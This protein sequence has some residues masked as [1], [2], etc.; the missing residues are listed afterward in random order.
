MRSLPSRHVLAAVVSL[1]VAPAV[2]AEPAAG[3]SAAATA[4]APARPEPA[5][6][7]AQDA[8]AQ[9][10]LEAEI[11]KELGQGA[12]AGGAHAALGAA[13]APAPAPQG[14]PEGAKGGNPFARVLL[15]PDISAIGTFAGAYDGYDVNRLSPRDGPY[16]PAGKPT[17]LFRELELGLQSVIDPYLRGDVFIS[18][19]PS[20]VA[21]EE[22]Y[23]TTLGLPAGLQLRAGKLFSPFGRLNQQHPHVWDF[24]DAPLALNRLLADEVLS[25]PG[26]D[27]SWLAPLPWFAELSV[28]GQGTSPT[29][30][31]ED[32]GERLTGVARLLQYFNLGDVTTVGVGL[33]AAR[34]SEATGAFRDLGGADVYV[35]FRRAASRASVSLQGEIVTVKVTDPGTPA[36]LKE[37]MPLLVSAVARGRQTG[38]Y[39]QLFWRPGPHLGYGVRYDQAPS[40]GEAAPGDERRYSAVATW[41]ASEFQRLR[42]QA[43]YDTR[44]ASQDGVEVLVGL[45]FIMGSHGAHPF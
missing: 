26:V 37:A 39:A 13:P 32:P 16:G 4:A 35:K 25:G 27:A 19:T 14:Q 6:A 21:V 20:E 31:V 29:P 22:A 12:P 17:P 11:A 41:Y 5:Q 18:F 24:I 42:I 23:A 34:R 9:R 3:T 28:A 10:K 15:L 33:S 36:Q 45:E 7:T 30:T 1:S 8:E 44:P 2:R 43:T 40:A 38:G